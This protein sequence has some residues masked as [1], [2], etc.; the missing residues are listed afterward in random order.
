[1]PCGRASGMRWFVR[2]AGLTRLFPFLARLDA[3]PGEID[4]A[5]RRGDEL[6]S[7]AQATRS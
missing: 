3:L 6:E 5:M 2:A 1:M 7:V 4:A